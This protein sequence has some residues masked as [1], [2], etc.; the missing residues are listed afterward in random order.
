MFKKHFDQNK[1]FIF[2]NCDE[3]KSRESMNIFYNNKVYR[4]VRDSR[5]ELWND[6][7]KQS[8]DGKIFI[9]PK[10]MF[11]VR[12]EILE[13]DPELVTAHIKYGAVMPLDI[14]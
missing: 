3:N 4:N 13:G 9:D 14:R 2:F 10:D 7:K 6:I 8:D 11:F 12:K 5:N 1:A